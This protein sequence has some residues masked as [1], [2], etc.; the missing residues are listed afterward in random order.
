MKLNDL[1]CHDARVNTTGCCPKFDPAG[2]DAQE[3]H[4][5]DKPFVQAGTRSESYVPQD[6]G[7][8]FARVFRH[9]EEA[10]AASDHGPIVL[11]R[12]LSPSSAEHLFAVSK[13]VPDERMTVLSGDFVTKVF[14]GPYERTGQWRGEMEQ[15]VRERHAVPGEVYF[16]YTTCPRCAQAYGRNYVVGIAA[17]E[18]AA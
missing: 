18:P 6:M 13:P 15:L 4:F 9:I 2:W 17:L 7:E 5:R 3:L 10:G 8:V 1:P 16:F 11:S 14:E 12:D